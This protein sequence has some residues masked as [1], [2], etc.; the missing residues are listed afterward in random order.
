MEGIL[1]SFYNKISARLFNY[2]IIDEHKAL[3]NKSNVS[4]LIFNNTITDLTTGRSCDLLDNS[5]QEIALAA[6]K[7]IPAT[8]KKP[9]ITL[10]LPANEFIATSYQLPQLEQS[11]RLAGLY[12]QQSDLLPAC[13]QDLLVASPIV[14]DGSTNQAIWFS[15]E[16]SENLFD[17]LKKYG[18]TLVA[19]F[20]ASVLF[21]INKQADDK[22]YCEQGEDYLLVTQFRQQNLRH[23]DFYHHSDLDIAE[24]R[25]QFQEQ[26][27]AHYPKCSFKNKDKIHNKDVFLSYIDKLKPKKD[28]GFYPKQAIALI[29]KEYQSHKLQIIAFVIVCLVLLL[30]SPFIKNI[31]E[32]KRLEQAYLRHWQQT[33][34][35]RN[36]RETVV[37]YEQKW[38]AFEQYPQ[39][40]LHQI[41]LKINRL[42]P[43]NS[44]LSSFEFN[45][46]VIEIEG[47]SPSPSKIL[48]L[49]AQQKEFDNAAFNQNVRAERGKKKEHFGIIFHL[50]DYDEKTYYEE[51]FPRDE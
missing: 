13:R 38:L 43:K 2:F 34:T 23:W 37:N 22:V 15:K 19:I 36:H 16:R 50:V 27:L 44:W 46:G 33:E 1:N 17:A 21:S 45:K 49:L 4:L 28:Y 25:Q 42:I 47:Y 11:Q 7:I 9:C 20:P 51:F 48:E 3:L 40:D 39:R 30:S 32:Y 31:L 6:K 41:L 5:V 26:W 8:I 14:A 12:Y 24:F 29:Q 35:V 10:F 18:F